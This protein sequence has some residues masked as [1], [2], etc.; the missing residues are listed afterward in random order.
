MLPESPPFHAFV[1]P[2]RHRSAWW[3]VL[4]GLVVVGATWFG[5]SLALF[6]LT[7]AG[8]LSP[9]G[10]APETVMPAGGSGRILP[11]AGVM[12]FLLTFAGV[13][14][15]LW[16]VLRLVHR[17]PFGTLFHPSGRPR[18][19]A[20]LAG[21]GLGLALHAVGLAVSFAV[22]GAPERTGL[23]LWA[24]A[25]WV[26]PVLVGVIFQATSEELLFRGYI[27]QQF[28]TWSRHPLVWAVA[29]AL[30][31]AV[32]HYDGGMDAGMRTLMLTHILLAGL[33]MAALVWRT[34]GLGAAMGLH[35]VNN[36][37]A[38]AL[39]GID[40]A[41]FGF[42]LWLYPPDAMERLFAFDLCIGLALLAAIV[43]VRRP[44]S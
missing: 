4:I 23:P 11:P 30:G 21:A 42:E 33:I 9:L 6:A 19:R 14:L 17:R 25:P 15:G 10:L 26:L 16:I 31:F 20:V 8:A 38:I 27:L 40:G 35:I 24:W 32:L 22:L 39:V 37:I 44:A 28:A 43:L 2:A 29:P 36:W 18:G 5:V 12:L 13:W 34:G 7:G 1:A 3:R 41:G